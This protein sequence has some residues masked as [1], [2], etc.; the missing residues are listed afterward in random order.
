[1]AEGFPQY[2]PRTAL[3]NLTL[4]E[5]TV[6]EEVD[7]AAVA[8]TWF[9]ALVA[10]ITTKDAAAFRDLFFAEAWW[11]D[12]VA[13]SWTIT[14]KQ[15]PAT[16]SDHIL[17]STAKL[18]DAS[19]ITTLPL[20]PLLTDMGPMTVIQFGYAF[21]TQYGHGRGVVRLGNDGPGSWKAWTVSSQLEGI[22]EPGENTNFQ[23]HHDDTTYQVLIVGAGTSS[24][25][26]FPLWFFFFSFSFC[27][28]LS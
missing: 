11:R 13:F 25:P 24:S 27:L 1:M 22:P 26:I 15:G 18:Q 7:A 17:G 12:S 16:I 3:P 14:S 9:S 20:A 19:V 10:S 8:Q 2:P 21:T 5:S 23:A 28:L 4:H 6:R